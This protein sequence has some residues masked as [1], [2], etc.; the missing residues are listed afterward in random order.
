MEPAFDPKCLELAEYF[1]E[2]DATSLWTE[3]EKRTL[4][5]QIQQTVEDFMHGH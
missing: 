5:A 4:A 1:L 2:N 3:K